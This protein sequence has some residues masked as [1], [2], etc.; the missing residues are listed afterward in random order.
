MLTGEVL[1]DEAGA[2]KW[3]SNCRVVR[4]SDGSLQLVVGS[5]RYDVVE[6]RLKSERLCLQAKPKEGPMC[7]VAHAA[8]ESEIRL[9]PPSL[10]SDAHKA[11]SLRTRETRR[12]TQTSRCLFVAARARSRTS[13]R[14]FDDVRARRARS[15]RAPERHVGI[16]GD[17]RL[18]RAGKAVVKAARIKEIFPTQDPEKVQSEKIKQRD[19]EI[20]RETRRKQRENSGRGG[21]G[22]RRAAMTREFLEDD[23]GQY[24]DVGIADVKAKSRGATREAIF[25][26][27][28]DDDDDDDGFDKRGRPAAGVDEEESEDGDFIDN[29]DPEVEE[30]E[31]DDEAM[32][33]A[34]PPPAKMARKRSP[35]PDDDLF[36]GGG[37]DDDEPAAPPAAPPAAADAPA[38]DDDDGRPKKR[39][40]IDMG[41]DDY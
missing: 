31:D 28:S 1:R 35:S 12:G 5:E 34:P 9:R 40:N 16:V 17:V 4:W 15:G 23:G 30:E 8:L 24:D 7:L 6:R 11:F 18:P 41:G 25:G 27:D 26:D 21:F 20:R 32:A 37:D 19:D 3:S 14:N 39:R 22:G 36:G 29:G 38:A 10:A 2:P 13:R 33:D